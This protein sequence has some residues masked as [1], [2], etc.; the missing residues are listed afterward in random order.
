M[1]RY[2]WHGY[3]NEL[4]DMDGVRVFGPLIF[5]GERWLPDPSRRVRYYYV[6]ADSVTFDPDEAVAS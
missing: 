1:L 4:L 2:R 5:D 6:P 3:V